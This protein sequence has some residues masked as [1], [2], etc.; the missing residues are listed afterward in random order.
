MKTASQVRQE[1]LSSIQSMVIKVIPEIVFDG[2]KVVCNNL[3]MTLSVEHALDF[4]TIRLVEKVYY[5]DINMSSGQDVCILSSFSK[6]EIAIKILTRYL[7]ET[8]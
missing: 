8:L 5:P 1:I 3:E 2:N 6:K 7:E 4:P